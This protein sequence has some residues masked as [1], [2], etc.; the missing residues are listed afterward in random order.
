MALL[1]K[2]L[3][4]Y[5][6]EIKAAAKREKAAAVRHDDLSDLMAVVRQ[7]IAK[8]AA[9]M[10]QKTSDFDLSMRIERIARSSQTLTINEWRRSVRDTLGVDLM[11]DYYKGEFFREALRTWRDRNVRLIST[12]PRDSLAEMD[13]IIMEGYRNGTSTTQIMKDI[14]EQYGVSKRRARF[15]ARDQVRMA[16]TCFATAMRRIAWN[17]AGRAKLSSGWQGHGLA[18]LSKGREQ[19]GA[20]PQRLG[21]AKQCFDGQRNGSALIWTARLAAELHRNP[22]QWNSLAEQCH[23]SHSTAEA[24]QNFRRI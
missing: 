2:S 19:H 11:E 10:E 3:K 12:I 1:S 14:Q 6:P 8:V 21:E 18:Q 22:R 16:M 15:I 13:N 17:S 4:M 5:L 7:V 23:A 20:A 9:D 24:P